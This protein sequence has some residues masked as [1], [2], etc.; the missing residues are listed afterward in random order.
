MYEAKVLFLE[1]KFKLK[2]IIARRDK[3]YAKLKNDVM[4]VNIL[5]P[6]L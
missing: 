3:I 6:I 5:A 2:I 4:I 1:F